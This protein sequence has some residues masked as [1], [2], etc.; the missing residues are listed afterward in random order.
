VSNKTFGLLA[1]KTP[2]R[3]VSIFVYNAQEAEI[4]RGMKECRETKC[5]VVIEYNIIAEQQT[6]GALLFA[7]N[8]K[9][10]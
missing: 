6:F 2:Q 10:A 4:Y 5:V 9:D 8:S 1:S 3:L 7:F